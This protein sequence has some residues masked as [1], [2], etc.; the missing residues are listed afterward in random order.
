LE[1]ISD[2][3]RRADVV[4]ITLTDL[5]RGRVY[6]AVADEHVGGRLVEVDV[7]CIEALSPALILYYRQIRE[8]QVTGDGARKCCSDCRGHDVGGEAEVEDVAVASVRIEVETL[9]LLLRPAP[10]VRAQVVGEPVLPV[11]PV[12]VLAVSFTVVV[13]V[14]NAVEAVVFVGLALLPL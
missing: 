9:L 13:G 14:Q 12:V 5:R 8:V 4:A 3:S 6:V 10:V 2:L 7:R 11:G 1:T